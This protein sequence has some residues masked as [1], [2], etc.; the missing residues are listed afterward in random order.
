MRFNK[1]D[2]L[3]TLRSNG[4]QVIVGIS[5]YWYNE[6][7]GPLCAGPKS[8]ADCHDTIKDAYAKNLQGG[9]LEDGYYHNAIGVVNVMNEP[10][11]LGSEL[12]LKAMVTAF[13]GILSAEK[14]AGVKKWNDGTLPRLTIT[15]SFA[16]AAGGTVTCDEKHFIKDP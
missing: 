13:D 6:A 1:K 12:Y 7:G 4:L 8:Q 3:D 14:D 2:F 15:W 5:S 9:F 10:D 16:L 11:F